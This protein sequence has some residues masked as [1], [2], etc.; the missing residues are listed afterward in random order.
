[1]YKNQAVECLPELQSEFAHKTHKV[2]DSLQRNFGNVASNEVCWTT[3][4]LFL[5]YT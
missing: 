2:T 5:V 4:D 3:M 1:M